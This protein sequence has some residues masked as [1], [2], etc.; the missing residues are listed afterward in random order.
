MTSTNGAR[1]VDEWLPIHGWSK[2][3]VRELSGYRGLFHHWTYDSEPGARDWGGSSRCSCSICILA[4]LRDLLLNSRRRPR[5]ANLYAAVE[6]EIG[7]RFKRDRSLAEII[8]LSQA[9]DAPEPGIVLPD[10][11]PDFIAMERAVFDALKHP[12]TS[13]LVKR[14]DS[15]TSRE[16]GCLSCIE[17]PN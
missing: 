17:S 10:S 13:A 11:G 8:E 4:S 2:A 15:A 7:H 9:A 14:T 5:L 1:H 3:Q 16:G 12:A 6:Q